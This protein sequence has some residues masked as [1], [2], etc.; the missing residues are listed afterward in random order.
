MAALMFRNQKSLDALSLKKYAAEAG[1]VPVRFAADLDSG[2]YA[3]DVLLE[4][5]E[6]ERVGVAGTPFFF[7]NGVWLKWESTDVAGIRAAVDAALAKAAS[8]RP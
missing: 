7:V 4:A 2:R 6:G 3:A 1:C 5:R 8:S